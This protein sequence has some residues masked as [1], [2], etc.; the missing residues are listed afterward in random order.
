MSKENKSSKVIFHT[1]GSTVKVIAGRIHDL[2]GERVELLHILDPETG[3]DISSQ[4]SREDLAYFLRTAEIKMG[5][6]DAK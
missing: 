3:V 5:I 1:A 4:Q 6:Q 2:P